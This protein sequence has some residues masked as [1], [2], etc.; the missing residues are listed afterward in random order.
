MIEKTSEEELKARID[1]VDI[2]SNYIELKISGANYKAKCPFHGEKTPSFIVSPS[3]QIFRCFGCGK[4]GDAIE[5]VKEYEN[6]GY[7]EA[8]EKIASIINFQLKYEI[9]NNRKDDILKIL[10]LVQDWYRKNLLDSKKS[11][12]YLESRGIDKNSIEK[13]GIGYSKKSDDL[14]EFLEKNFINF[15]D[16]KEVGV[17]SSKDGKFFA[18]LRDRITFPIHNQNGKL[19][20]FGGRTV[21]NHSAK[22]INSPQTKFF[23]KSKILYG[24]H[25]A[26]ESIYKT[27]EIIVTEGYLDV[28]LLHQ[29]GYK[30]SV[31]TLGTALTKEHIPLLK[32]RE[33]EVILAYD[34]D[35]AGINACFK[36]SM[37]LSINGIAGRVVLFPD[38]L[39]PADLV[40]KKEIDKLKTLL[41]GGVNL[42]EFTLKGI[43]KGFN[44]KN[45]YQKEKAFNEI[46][47]YLSKLSDI[48]REEFIPI[49]SSLLGVSPTLFNESL[50]SIK[51]IPKKKETIKIDIVEDR[52]NDISVLNLLKTLIDN[53][54][55]IDILKNI[56][57]KSI[58]GEH[59]SIYKAIVDKDMDNPKVMELSS[60]DCYIVLSPD[61]LKG[62]L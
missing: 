61:E 20:G 48:I 5:F 11:L 34:G 6:L 32:K 53:P 37:L 10:T 28:I 52:C 46:K 33:I 51:K 23:N 41:D 1:I 22:Y 42:I 35:E 26:K 49:A 25:I 13:F 31:A 3:K 15:N 8:L 44:I 55:M 16:A 24:Y 54:K 60:D 47:V 18:R 57:I 39:D 7:Y 14:L 30:N 17:V 59:Q 9:D 19:V 58:F 12:K 29:A 4:G 40:Y 21:S 56:D 50:N 45:P 36:A 43:I 62:H 2:I 38:G 27:E